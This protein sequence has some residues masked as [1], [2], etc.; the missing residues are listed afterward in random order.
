MTP[1]WESGVIHRTKRIYFVR[2]ASCFQ[3]SSAGLIYILKVRI[4]ADA[5][6]LSFLQLRME[7]DWIGVLVYSMFVPLVRVFL[8]DRL[9]KRRHT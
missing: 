2:V 7:L 6:A 5:I 9:L 4:R 1:I 3:F 8:I